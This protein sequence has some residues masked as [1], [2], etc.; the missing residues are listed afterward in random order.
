MKIPK[1]NKKLKQCRLGI[2]YNNRCESKLGQIYTLN[3][4]DAWITKRGGLHHGAAFECVA[5][6]FV[7][8][9]VAADAESFATALMWAFEWLLSR[10]RV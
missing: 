1:K 6:A 4:S 8:L 10:V 9:H 7:A 5:A 3:L 2:S